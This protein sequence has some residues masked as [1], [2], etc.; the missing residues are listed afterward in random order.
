MSC[1]SSP[2]SYVPFPYMSC[3][4]CICISSPLSV[5]MLS[6][7]MYPFRACLFRVTMSPLRVSHLVYVSCPFV[8]PLRIYP[9]SCL[10]LFREY[11]VCVTYFYMFLP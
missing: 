9:L 4:V 7:Y 11:C 6:S 1:F 10:F 2:F 5:Y 3:L 8:A